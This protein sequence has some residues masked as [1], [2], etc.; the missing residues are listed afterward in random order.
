MLPGVGRGRS[1]IE[2]VKHLDLCRLGAS[3]QIAADFAQWLEIAER[4][5]AA[6][7]TSTIRHGSIAKAA[8]FNNDFR[9]SLSVPNC[10]P[11]AVSQAGYR[12]T[13]L[14]ILLHR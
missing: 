4:G 1:K 14:M 10:L 8:R 9:R 5:V 7:R 11:K 2:R 3:F 6:T 12:M 13:A